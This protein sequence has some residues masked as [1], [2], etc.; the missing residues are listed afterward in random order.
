[1]N[2]LSALAGV[3][4]YEFAMQLRRPALWVGL[5]LISALLFFAFGSMT[6]PDRGVPATHLDILILWTNACNFLLTVGAGLLLADRTPRDRKTRVSELL[7]TSPA[8]ALT[9]ITGKYVGSI[10]ATLVPIFLI[11][12]VGAGILVA[13]WG[14]PGMIPLALATFAALNVPAVLF[15]GAFS[16]ACTTVLWTPLY[17][18]LFVGYWLW[19][20]LNPGEA[21]PTLSGTLLSPAGNYVVTGFF[22]FGSYLPVDRG[23]YPHSSVGL[24][25][26]NIAVLLGAGALALVAAWRLQGSRA[27]YQ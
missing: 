8:S 10:A 21:I 5:S 3:I 22:H 17:Q 16:V 12:A 15:V 24:G 11:Y 25:V 14:N 20:S 13:R 6:S 23:F 9:R 27:A 18:F 1:M 2:Q 26:A 19:T 7:R 4:R